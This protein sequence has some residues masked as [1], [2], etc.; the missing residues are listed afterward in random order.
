MTM[1]AHAA[2]LYQFAPPLTPEGFLATVDQLVGSG[3]DTLV[4][5]AGLEGGVALYDS[6]VSQK[7]GDNVDTWKQ[8]FGIVP[9]AISSSSLRPDMIR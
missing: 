5:F 4:Y 2:P 8:P 1:G 6:Q 7:W 9:H 3:F